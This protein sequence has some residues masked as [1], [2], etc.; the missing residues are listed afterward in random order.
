MTIFLVMNIWMWQYC[1]LLGTIVSMFGLMPSL[2]VDAK[3]LATCR[4]FLNVTTGKLFKES[5][6]VYFS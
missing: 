5:F 4:T 1:Q 6:Y 2:V 3:Q